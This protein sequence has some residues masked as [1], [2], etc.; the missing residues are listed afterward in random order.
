MRI[1]DVYRQQWR[2]NILESP[3]LQ[4]YKE[5]K[6]LLNPERYL[7]II[8]NF[9]IRRSLAK[10]RCS[11]HSLTIE[12]GRHLKIER[13]LRLCP[14]CTLSCVEDEFH[15]LM[16]CPAFKDLRTLYLPNFQTTYPSWGKFLTILTSENVDVIKSLSSYVYQGLKRRNKFQ[17]VS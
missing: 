8:N 10:L 5:F 7:T 14:C 13:S 9:Y 4:T 15:F 6:T 12:K 2:A 16:I 3:K 17:G 11:D 1:S